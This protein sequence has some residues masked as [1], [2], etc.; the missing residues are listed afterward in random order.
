M[1][2]SNVYYTPWISSPLIS[3]ARLCG[4]ADLTFTNASKGFAIVCDAKETIIFKI[5]E[6]NGV[7]PLTT[8]RP[9]SGIGASTAKQPITL[10]EAH[11]RL[12]HISYDVIRHLV[13]TERVTG[14]DVDLSTPE[15]DCEMCIKAKSTRTAVPNKGV[16]VQFSSVQQLFCR[17]LKG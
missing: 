12:G 9:V 2:L 11:C 7:Y 15:N 14:F 3:V 8:W 1:S 4:I 13:K 6:R 5:S 10:H 17:T 16:K